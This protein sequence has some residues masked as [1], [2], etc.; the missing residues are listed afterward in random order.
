M[1][2]G[3]DVLPASS[4]AAALE[5]AEVAAAIAAL[6]QKRI[7]VRASRRTLCVGQDDAGHYVGIGLQVAADDLGVG[8]VRDA[9]N[10]VDR[11][12]LLVDVEPRATRPLDR[13][14]R[15]EERVD[16]RRRFGLRTAF[17]FGRRR[18]RFFKHARVAAASFD[19]LDELLLFVGRHRLEA[20]E[21]SGLTIAAAFGIAE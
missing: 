10:H 5:A 2:S 16:G 20:F 15:R 3:I 21:H 7:A 8:A 9:G 12:E 11:L 19:A 1:T 18:H 14:E 4:A 13:R 17:W 6:L